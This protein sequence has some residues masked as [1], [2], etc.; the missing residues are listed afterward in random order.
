MP[1]H[2][3]WCWI[4]RRIIE[5]IRRKWKP[6]PNNELRRFNTFF[7][8]LMLW[9]AVW[10]WFPTC[11]M[12]PNCFLKLHRASTYVGPALSLLKTK[13]IYN[14]IY[15]KIIKL[16]SNWPL[17]YIIYFNFFL[18]TIYIYIYFNLIFNFLTVSM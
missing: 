17:F 5:S 9:L 4:L 6:V 16:L 8:S 15:K 7:V 11:H 10:Y 12:R 3:T 18:K 1:T 14:Y 13:Q 2:H